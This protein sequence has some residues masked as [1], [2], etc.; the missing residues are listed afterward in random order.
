VVGSGRVGKSAITMQFVTGT[1]LERYD[2]TRDEQSFHPKIEITDLP[3][4]KKTGFWRK[5]FKKK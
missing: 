2:P 1:F 3:K 5:I 4:E